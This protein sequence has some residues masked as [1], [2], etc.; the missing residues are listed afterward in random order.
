MLSAD[1]LGVSGAGEGH[2]N[3]G[4]SALTSVLASGMTAGKLILSVGLP[5]PGAI[6]NSPFKKLALCMSFVIFLMLV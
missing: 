2:D 3:D 1:E 5:K 6:V 4:K